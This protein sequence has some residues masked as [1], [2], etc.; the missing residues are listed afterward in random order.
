MLSGK[1]CRVS[2]W[3]CVKDVCPRAPTEQRRER[4]M[5]TG[6]YC[7]GYIARGSLFWFRSNETRVPD[8]SLFVSKLERSQWTRVRVRVCMILPFWSF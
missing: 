1:E 8:M 2:S 5:P 3:L 4:V 7:T 6:G